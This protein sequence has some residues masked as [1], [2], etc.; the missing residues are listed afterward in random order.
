MGIMQKIQQDI[1]L[2]IEVRYTKLLE[3][4]TGNVSD[5]TISF[6]HDIQLYYPMAWDAI[7]K[8]S[9]VFVAILEELYQLGMEEGLFRPISIDLLKVLD[10]YFVTE[11]ISNQ[12]IFKDPNYTLDYLVRDYLRLRLEGLNKS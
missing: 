3:E 12:K 1:S 7:N 9:D 2:P 4:F 8:V 11:I 10:R 6:F 5:I